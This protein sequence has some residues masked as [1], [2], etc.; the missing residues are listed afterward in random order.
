MVV[1]IRTKSPTFGQWVSAE[2]WTEIYIPIGSAHEFVTLEENTEVSYKLSDFYTPDHENGILWND[3]DLAIDWP[4]DPT[5][6]QLSE[7]D[8]SLPRFNALKDHLPF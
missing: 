4:I 1:D 3:P 2:N 8:K 7:K 5:Q 6:V